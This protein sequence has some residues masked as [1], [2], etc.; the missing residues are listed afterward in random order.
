[1]G[2]SKKRALTFAEAS[3]LFDSSDIFEVG[4]V[5][6]VTD[7][8][9]KLPRHKYVGLEVALFRRISKLARQQHKS[10]ELLIQE[11][12]REKVG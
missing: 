9:F 3:S 4:S 12:L 10:E 5:A 7:V 11:W 1:M 6:E 8:K 2:K